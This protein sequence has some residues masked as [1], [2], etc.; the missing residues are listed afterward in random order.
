MFAMTALLLPKEGLKSLSNMEGGKRISDE[1]VKGAD[2]FRL[3]G[4]YSKRQV[5]LWID[6]K[7]FLLRRMDSQ[8]ESMGT[9]T[10]RSTIYDPVV[11]KDIPD[12][13]LE[14][15]APEKE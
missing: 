4:K 10:E 7:T 6:K 12:K 15:N 5:T 1:K 13:S 2:C 9:R 3:T 11:G 14:L 8:Q